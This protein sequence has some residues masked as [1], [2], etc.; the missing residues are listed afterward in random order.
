MNKI[1]FTLPEKQSPGRRPAAG[2]FL[3]LLCLVAGLAA[4]QARAQITVSPARLFFEGKPGETV[5]RTVTLSNNGKIPYEFK[6]GLKDWKRDSLGNKLYDEPGKLPHSNAKTIKLNESV[7]II[8]PGENKRIPVYMEIPENL[9]DATSTNSMLFF[10][11]NISDKEQGNSPSIGLKVGFEYGIQIFYTPYGAKPGE[12]EFLEFDYSAQA[13]S[14]SIRIKYQNTGGLH[15]TAVLQFE[16]TNKT[17]GEE[18]KMDRVDL[19]IMPFDSQVLNVHLPQEITAGEY[20]VV[21]L[22]TSDSYQSKRALKV[23]KKS[24]YVK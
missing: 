22:L 17:T 14:K 20:L 18:L 6:T 7:V 10:T 5:S 1:P 19:A 8:Q 3:L 15:K 9:T 2:R 16:L 4:Q 11:Q 21:A 24:I 23:A 12:L 13:K